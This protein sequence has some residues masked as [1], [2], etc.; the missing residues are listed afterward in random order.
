MHIPEGTHDVL[1]LFF[2]LGLMAV[3][4]GPMINSLFRGKFWNR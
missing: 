1:V 4:M 2:C 3:V